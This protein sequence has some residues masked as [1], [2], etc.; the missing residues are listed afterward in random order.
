MKIDRDH[1]PTAGAREDSS[2]LTEESG[3]RAQRVRQILES[4]N[5][6]Q[7]QRAP[8]GDPRQDRRPD[9]Q[10]MQRDREYMDREGGRPRPPVRRK[11][12]LFGSRPLGIFTV[13]PDSE[14]RAASEFPK[15]STW[16]ALD[17]KEL[18]LAVT[19]PPRNGF[20]EMILW[21]EQ[22]KLWKFPIDNEQGMDEEANIPF[23]Q[24][25][26]LEPLI[27]PWC[28]KKGPLRHFM[29]LVCVAL[30]KNHFMTVKEKHEYIEWYHQFFLE[31]ASVLKE[32][33]AGDVK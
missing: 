17:A 31:R 1:Q 14:Y 2:S 33:G 21:T 27:E 29:E 4:Q 15:L 23:H 10:Y 12:D 5:R 7:Q 22:G 20:E 9:R 24:H 16:D 26:F 18:K 6:Y 32:T 11:V 13:K 30:G 28:P 3:S 8:L 19:H 25:V